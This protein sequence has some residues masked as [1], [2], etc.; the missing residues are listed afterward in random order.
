MMIHMMK[1]STQLSTKLTK[2][3]RNKG[4]KLYITDIFT[5]QSH[6]GMDAASLLCLNFEGVGGGWNW[7]ER[8]KET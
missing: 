2:V 3:K 5:F 1:Q 6:A 8:E 4:P 7:E